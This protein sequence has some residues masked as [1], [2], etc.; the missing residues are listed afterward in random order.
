MRCLKNRICI[1]T[2]VFILVFSLLPFAKGWTQAQA[3]EPQ[4]TTQSSQLADTAYDGIKAQVTD[5]LVDNPQASYADDQ[6]IVVFK[7][8]VSSS[9]A[10]GILQDVP[11]VDEQSVDTDSMIADN[12]TVAQLADGATV[13]DAITQLNANPDVAYA[14]PNYLYEPLDDPTSNPEQ[15][16]PTS[17]DGTGTE[18]Q[19]DQGVAL[20]PQ[21]T[22]VNDPYA[23]QEWSLTTTRLYDAWSLTQSDRTVGVAVIDT[24]VKVD[25]EDLA[26]T[27]IPDSYYDATGTGQTGDA[28]NHGTHV[29]GI[30]AAEAN[31]GLGI[32]GVSY[33]AQIIPICTGYYDGASYVMNTAYVCNAYDYLFQQMPG[34]EITRAQAYNLKVINISL[35]GY[36]E[37]PLLKT[38]IDQAYAAGVL[39]VC[40]A[41]NDGLDSPVYP[42]SYDDC[43][44]VA[45]LSQGTGILQDIRSTSSNYGDTID[46]SA[47]GVSIYSTVNNGGYAMMSGTSMASPYVAGVAALLFAADPSATV[48]DVM[49]TIK[50]TAA[51]RGD[52]GWDPYYGYGEVDPYHAALAIGVTGISNTDPTYPLEPITCTVKTT[53]PQPITWIWSVEGGDATI[54]PDG[55]LIPDKSG[56]ITVRATYDQDSSVYFQKDIVVPCR[57]PDITMDTD[58]FT[59]DATP[60]TPLFSVTHQSVPLV[61]DTDYTLSISNNLN[62]GT[63]VATFTSLNTVDWTGQATKTFTINPAPISAATVTVPS[64][65]Y[66]GSPVTPEPVVKF[67]N[68]LG[69]T[70]TLIKGTDY[71]LT[72]SNNTAVSTSAPTVTITGKGNFTGTSTKTFTINPAPISTA[73]VTVPSATY[74][75]SALTP[76]P[77]VKYTVGIGQIITLTK[78]VD[79]TVTYSNNTATTQAGAMATIT[80]IGNFTGITTKTFTINPA[81]ISTA[82]VTV[83]SAT[84]IGSPVTSE[85]VVK[86]TNG[87][88]QVVTLVKGTDYTVT[89]S[90]NT[91]ITDAGAKVTVTGKGNFTGTTTKGFSIKGMT[92]SYASYVQGTGWQ[93]MREEGK[94]SGTVGE[95]KRVEALQVSLVN[96]TG[97]TGSLVYQAQVQKTGWQA[98]KTVRS[99]GTSATPSTGPL[100]GTTGQSL[101]LETLRFKLTGDLAQHYDIYYRVHVQNIGWMGWAKNGEDAGTVGLALRVEALQICLVPAGGAQPSNGYGGII[102]A[103]GTPCAVDGSAAVLK[104]GLSFDAMVHIQKKGN[105]YFTTANGSTILGT[106]GQS[107]RLEAMQVN[108]LNKPVSGG[109]TYQVHVQNI[110][111]Q[112]AVS[113]GQL[114]GT[115]GQALRLEAVRIKLTGAMAQDYDVYYRTHIQKFGWT[116]WAKNGQ[117]CGSAG[118]GYRM[119]AMQIVIV[120]KDSTAPGLNTDYFHQK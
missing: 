100:C 33:N 80:G 58:T 78:G 98:E 99:T 12:A 108:L 21:A 93:S 28:Y 87:N 74:N 117:S 13:E 89:Y 112:D 27:I 72:Y 114:A 5:D 19:G 24:G 110:G 71:T 25:H 8:D 10:S 60:K 18:S 46:V 37:D 17:M 45:S 82:T 64:A 83:P 34:E 68:G 77:V 62:A 79:Y 95:G 86:F 41:G 29:A 85:P 20:L 106:T 118:Y 23:D 105:T 75:G 109:L 57:P 49:Q 44:N 69:Q 107:L 88:A 101:R 40:A 63:A 91:S 97:Y 48:D 59:Y 61:K 2:V 26:G 4:D 38:K 50:D 73:T 111:W 39:T 115:E 84:Y 51:D 35:G 31:N 15:T 3:E 36:N 96:N 70:Q 14:Q 30:I 104:A 32:A 120:K 9:E 53:L 54:D 81:P 92:I 65:T 102:T 6:V 90:S 7:D 76:A 43:L 47:P 55:I 66:T 16:N 22:S 103:L 113:E 94:L 67:T 1:P 56:T 52:P 11:S 116:G 42:G 119:E